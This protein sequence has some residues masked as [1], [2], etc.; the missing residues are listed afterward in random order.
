M[1]VAICKSEE[2]P[3]P[4]RINKVGKSLGYCEEHLAE[5]RRIYSAEI[6]VRKFGRSDRYVDQNGYIK[7]ETSSGRMVAE[8]RIVMENLLGRELVAG[9]SVHHI[10]G[11]RSDNRPENLELWASPQPYGQRVE[12]LIAYVVLHHRDRLLAELSS[13]SDQAE[14]AS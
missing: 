13:F 1:K 3:R 10:N 12:Q 6:R 5:R 8:H 9:E 2:C 4:T 11:D 14:E 7:I